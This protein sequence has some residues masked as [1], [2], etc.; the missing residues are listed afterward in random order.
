MH[1]LQRTMFNSIQF[2]SF[3]K[4]SLSAISQLW[5]RDFTKILMLSSCTIRAWAELMH[6]LLTCKSVRI[7]DGL[8]KWLIREVLHWKYVEFKNIWN[9]SHVMVNAMFSL[10]F[11]LIRFFCC[12][13]RKETFYC[14]SM[15]STYAVC[16][17]HK[18][19][20]F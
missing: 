8:M 17:I 20:Q 15:V 1:Y 12:Q 3:I 11:N 19:W 5:Q 16:L 18:L 7:K 4:D 13:Y 10:K 2:K 14:Q 6:M 9:R